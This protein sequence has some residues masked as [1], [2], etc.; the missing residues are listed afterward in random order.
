MM[1]L[2]KRRRWMFWLGAGDWMA[3]VAGLLL[4]KYRISPGYI[5]PTDLWVRLWLDK[6][7]PEA[8]AAEIAEKF[9]RK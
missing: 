7:T 8:A 6:W 9:S 5:R 3:K 2:F 4:R 1:R